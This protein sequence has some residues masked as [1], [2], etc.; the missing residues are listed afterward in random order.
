M[1]FKI[2][3]VILRNRILILSI[4]FA[5][6]IVFGYFAITNIK[7]DSSYGTMLP[8]DSQPKK[9]YELL[10]ARFGGSE[11]LLIFGI[12]TEGLYTLDKFNAW[13]DFGAK[14]ASFSAIDSVFSEAHIYH[15]KKDTVNEKFFFDKIV[16]VAAANTERSR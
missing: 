10:K 9:D 16:K 15:L 11:S 1:W 8:K 7:M 6:T 2:S 12:Q 4:I 13:Y 3:Q 14:V 5:I